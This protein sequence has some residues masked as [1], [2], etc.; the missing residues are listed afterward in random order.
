MKKLALIFGTAAL[1]LAGCSQEESIPGEES[2]PNAIAFG[3]FVQKATK[4]TPVSGQVLPDGGEFLVMGK[5]D[6][7][8]ENPLDF[9]R[10]TVTF[11]DGTPDDYCTYSPTKY[12]P[13]SGSVNFFAVYPADIAATITPALGIAPTVDIKGLPVVE[14]TIPSDPARQKDLM[15]AAALSEVTGTPVDF[16]FTHKLTKIGFQATLGAQYDG[17][18]VR[19]TSITVDHLAEAVK[20]TVSG[21]G[22]WEMAHNSAFGTAYTLHNYNLL[23]NGAV[24]TVTTMTSI[25]ENNSYLM[26]API[27]ADAS[28]GA[29]V[30]VDYTVFYADGTSTENEASTTIP[31]ENIV[32]GNSISVNMTITLTGVTFTSG[33]TEWSDVTPFTM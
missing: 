10:Q 30:E 7:E 24:T 29:S 1:L 28:E 33:V 13:K 19:I 3:T 20:Y 21:S 32:A 23:N 31:K 18:Y 17:A 22:A 26:V 12:W 15:L 2:T 6:L 4:G 11:V 16:T 14:Y 8:A 27:A 5:T 9:M 25:V